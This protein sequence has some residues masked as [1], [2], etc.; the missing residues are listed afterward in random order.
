MIWR[1]LKCYKYKKN[2]KSA[3]SSENRIIHLA[4]MTNVPTA[5]KLLNKVQKDFLCGKISLRLNLTL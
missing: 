5:T 1:N 4:L 2:A 3:T